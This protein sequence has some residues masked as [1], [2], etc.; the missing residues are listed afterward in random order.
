M[1]DIAI[2]TTVTI[3]NDI[4]VGTDTAFAR[5]EQVIIQGVS[6]NAQGPEYKY[7]VMSS[8]T[9]QQCQLREVDFLPLAAASQPPDQRQLLLRPVLPHRQ[10]LPSN[11]A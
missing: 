3:A 5:G 6:P 9:G 1:A 11:F 10:M 7:M 4:I 2:G 8:R